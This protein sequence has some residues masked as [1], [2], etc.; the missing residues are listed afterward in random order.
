VTVLAGMLATTVVSVVL[1]GSRLQLSTVLGDSPI[2]AG[3]FS[4][5]NNVTFSQVMVVT[6]LLGVFLRAGRRDTGNLLAVLGLFAAVLL[7]LGAPMWGA[8]VGGVLAGFSAFAVTFTLLAGWRVRV[9]DALV[10]IALT[11]LVLVGLGLVDLLRPSDERTHLARLFERIGDEGWNGLAVVVGRKLDANLNTLAHS[12]WRF[13]LVP[14]VVIGV[15]VVWRAPDRVRRV[16][17]R[18][19][20]L[21]AGLVG[22]ATAAVLGYAVNDSGISVPAAMA[23]VLAAAMIHLLARVGPEP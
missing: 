7:V 20:D 9:R 8:D 12:V 16:L 5:I 6:I 1:L 21:R 2:V 15:L 11:L 14:L 4:G 22:I 10:W 19:P 18:V 13:L 23:A 3:R 17:A